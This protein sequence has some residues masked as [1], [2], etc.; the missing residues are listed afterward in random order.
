MT[1]QTI[2]RVVAKLLIPLILL[3][4]L[5]V[6]FHGDYSPGGGFQAGVIAGAAFVA[7]GQGRNGFLHAS[8]VLSS[9][10]DADWSLEQLLSTPVEPDAL[11]DD[12]RAQAGMRFNALFRNYE[13]IFYQFN[14]NMV[15][16]VV[17]DGWK[18]RIT[19]Y[20]WQPGVQAWWP[21]W[22]DDCHPDFKEFLESSE[23][24]SAPGIPVFLGGATDD[25]PA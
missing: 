25:P 12:A 19:R 20:F 5:Y 17:W 1:R 16:E 2:L 14:Q 24:P 11:D 22:R 10:G 21:T 13:N 15:D 3:F 7:F 18:H 6:Q 23:R 8:D 9:Y 4:A